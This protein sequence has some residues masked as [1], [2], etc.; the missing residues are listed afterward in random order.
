MSKSEKS[1]AVPPSRALPENRPSLSGANKAAAA[2]LAGRLG[3]PSRLRG[4]NFAEVGIGRLCTGCCCRRRRRRC[5]CRQRRQ[6]RRTAERVYA[7]TRYLHKRHEKV[8]KLRLRRTAQEKDSSQV[9]SLC[10]PL[11]GKLGIQMSRPA[12]QPESFVGR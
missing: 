5:R 1:C 4:G 8:V 10:R 12:G 7:H 11:F 9:L 2:L 3:R 6:S